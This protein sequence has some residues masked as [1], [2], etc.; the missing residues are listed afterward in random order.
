[1]RYR[2]VAVHDIHL[3]LEQLRRY[4]SRDAFAEFCGVEIEEVGPGRA[5]VSLKVEP[6]HLNGLGMVHGGVLFTLADMALAAAAHSRGRSAVAVTASM[7]FMKAGMTDVIH[8]EA[9]EVSRNRRLATY[10]VQVTDG[11]GEAL[12]LCQGTAYIRAETLQESPG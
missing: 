3:S 8:A 12:C 11:S 1:V 10:T 7:S 5:R 4:F 6:R 2:G 9:R